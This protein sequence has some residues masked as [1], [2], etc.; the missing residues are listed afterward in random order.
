MAASPLPAAVI[1][2]EGAE[3]VATTADWVTV[4]WSAS[5]EE[6]SDGSSSDCTDCIYE[7]RLCHVERKTC[8]ALDSTAGLTKTFRMP[9]SGHYTV[10]VRGCRGTGESRTCSEYASSVNEINQ[11][12]VNGAVKK[13]RLFGRPAPAGGPIVIQ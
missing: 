4:S 2:F 8:T 9:K 13:W 6:L 11:P 5:R 1:D 12:M 10:E 3:Y 7:V